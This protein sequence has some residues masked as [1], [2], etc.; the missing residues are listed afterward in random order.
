[1]ISYN[2]NELIPSSKISKN[3]GAFLKKISKHEMERVAVVKNNKLEAIILSIEEYE[4]L[5]ELE[6][7][8]EYSEIYNIASKREKEAKENYV[9]FEDILKEN[10][11][12][13][14]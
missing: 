9:D 8:L 2:K 5:K 7:L 13:L 14:K 11:I 1:M 3:F 4:K 10:K 12:K 6:E